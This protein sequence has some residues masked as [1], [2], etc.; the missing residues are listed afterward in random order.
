MVLYFIFILLVFMGN[1]HLP[2][3]V[4]PRSRLYPDPVKPGDLHQASQGV[5]F[6]VA[7]KQSEPEL[8]SE[9]STGRLVFLQVMKVAKCPTDELS[10][11]NCAVVSEQE[12]DVSRTRF[13]AV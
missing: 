8:Y 4:T 5:V 11:T 7:L 13:S 12:F 1:I 2:G 9:S 3:V 6:C 10:L